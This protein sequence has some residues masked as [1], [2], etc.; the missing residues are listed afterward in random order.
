MS[1]EQAGGRLGFLD[2]LTRLFRREEEVRPQKPAAASR[3]ESFQAEF[4]AALRALDEKIEAD[5]REA[6][7]TGSAKGPRQKRKAEDRA[8]EQLRHLDAVYRS[9]R[10][11]IEK[12]HARLGTGLTAADLDAIHDALE[13]IAPLAKSGRSSHALLP[14]ARYAIAARLQAEAGELAVTRLVELMR[15]A[16]MPWPD[17]TRYRPSASEEE[18]ERSRR[19]RL[20]E[21][22]ETFLV[23]DLEKTAHCMLGMVKAWGAGYPDRGSPLWEECVLEGV[24]AGIRGQLVMECVEVLRR[25]QGQLLGEVEAKVGKDLAELQ[26]VIQSGVTSIEQASRAAASALRVIDEVT[27][28]LAWERIRSEVAH[29]RGE[30]AS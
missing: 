23:H 19:R 13:E 3:S 18:I 4:E 10:E 11:D 5:R 28:D 14:R 8:A 27:P 21:V 24:G 29:A 9:I 16:Q 12:M 2:A 22:R 6:E 20:S 25:D 7:T 30:W 17:P 26:K 1:D 15:K